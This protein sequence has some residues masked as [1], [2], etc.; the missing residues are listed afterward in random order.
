MSATVHVETSR[1]LPLVSMMVGFK[2]GSVLDPPGQEGL[3]RLMVRMLRRG[4][5]GMDA[6]AIENAIDTL[7]AD[8]SEHVG[9]SSVSLQLEVIGRSFDG[10]VEM[11]G[12]LLCD[13]T[14]DPVELGKLQRETEGELIESRDNDRTLCARAFRRTVF[15]GHPLARRVSGLIP[16]LRSIQRDDVLHAYRRTLTRSNVVFAFSGD[17]D[18]A[19]AARA[20]ARIEAGLPEG[21]AP[22]RLIPEPPVRAGRRLVFVDK[23]DRT[24]TQ[25]LLGGLGTHPRDPDHI[26]LHVANTIFGGTFTSRLMREV[27]SKRGWSYG[28]YAS[29]PIDVCREAFSMWTHPGATDAAACLKLELQ[30]LEAL[31][32]G[33]VTARELAFTKRYLVRSHAFDVDTAS[34]RVH[35]KMA[36]TMYDLPEDY[37]T[38]YL[39]RV[40]S[41][42][43]EQAAE[44]VRTR[45]PSDNLVV[46]LTGTHAQIGAQVAEAIPGLVEQT[47]VPFDLE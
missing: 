44:A 18:E 9:A 31:R 34:K 27:R 23:P 22:Q 37:Y 13:P 8:I 6:P 47:V 5:A 41:V 43:V 20:A 2:A 21:P 42:T 39:E 36:V 45:L 32:A 26:P 35:R 40:A 16:S 25:L 10:A 3:T 46:A 30:L 19:T 24:Q 11:L 28:A 38:G 29:M 7:G 15:D 33:G 17:I 12:K 4:A 14:F 1:E